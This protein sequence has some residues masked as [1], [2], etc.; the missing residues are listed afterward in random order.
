MQPNIQ[1]QARLNQFLLHMV[2]IGNTKGVQKC[3]EAGADFTYDNGY[4][5]RLS[6]FLG[7]IEIFKLLYNTGI[8]PAVNSNDAICYA[9]YRGHTAIVSILLQDSRVNPTVAS[10]FA[11]KRAAENNHL[12]TTR[13]LLNHYQKNNLTIPKDL[14]RTKVFSVIQQEK[15]NML[16]M[17]GTSSYANA[18]CS[19]RKYFA[20]NKM[21]EPQLVSEIIKFVPPESSEVVDYNRKL[22]RFCNI[23]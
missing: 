2:T 10:H 15:V 9:S 8:N 12:D 5:F 11:I 23:L 1:V 21:F 4:A 19:L 17:Y 20:D 6:A 7:Y 16:F 22:F 13:V 3:L 14:T 18:D